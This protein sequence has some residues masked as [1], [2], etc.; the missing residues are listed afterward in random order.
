[1]KLRDGSPVWKYKTDSYIY[2]SPAVSA[3]RVVIGG[4]DGAVHVLKESDGSRIHAIPIGPYVGSSV[5][6]VGDKVYFGHFG[7]R[8]A[9]LDLRAGALLWQTP[10]TGFPYL[11]STAV[12]GS[13][14]Y[15]GSRDRKIY[16]FS[17]ED[18]RELWRFEALARVDGSPVTYGDAVLVGGNDG[19]LYQ[20]DRKDG[21]LL[22]SYDFGAPITTSAA[23]VGTWIFVGTHDGAV[24]GLEAGA[25]R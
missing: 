7:N 11:S 22:W 13:A 21:L 25:R 8:V 9:A 5:T 1:V 24:Y 6:V 2:G 10:D 4:C 3:G 18:G 15:I 14:L 17:L 16:A 19:R 23:V 20:L 12:D